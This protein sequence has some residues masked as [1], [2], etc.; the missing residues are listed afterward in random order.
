M[1]V[2]NSELSYQTSMIGALPYDMN[3]EQIGRAKWPLMTDMEDYSVDLFGEKLIQISAVPPMAKMTIAP[4]TLSTVHKLIVKLKALQNMPDSEKWPE[5]TW[6][7][8]QAFD[9]ANLFIRRSTLSSIPTPEIKLADD[10]EINFLWTGTRVHVDLG[11]YGTGTFSY[12]A[13]GKDG[14]R[15][16]GECV[17]ALE[18]LPQ[19]IVA[20][21]AA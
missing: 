10:G 19:E 20:L 12:F 7:I 16:H 15:L 14:R 21:F 4:S 17:S 1:T 2:H 6:P 18:G 5:S 9:D 3:V 11:F 8:A 13:R